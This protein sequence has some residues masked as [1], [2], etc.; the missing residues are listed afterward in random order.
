MKSTSLA[1][2]LLAWYAVHARE[3][4]WRGERDPYK[5]WVA[6]V[7]LQQT[8]VETVKPYYQRW[9][10][11]FPSLESLAMATQQE[12]LAAWE[13]L[14]YYSRAR[15]LHQAAQVVVKI[16]RG[17]IP[18]EV[19]SLRRLPGVGRY[20]AGAIASI[21][22]GK[23]VAA[24][25]GNQR[26]V[27][28]RLFDIDEPLNTPAGESRL[29]ELAEL[30]LPPRRAGDFNQALMD[31]GAT[32]CSPYAPACPECP[33][34]EMC[35]ARKLGVQEARPV[36]LVK[37]PTPH[38]PVAA[39]VIRRNGRVLITQRPADKLLGGMWEFPGG[40]QDDGE[41]LPAC[42]KRELLEELGVSVDVGAPFGVYR[43][44]YTHF[45]V[46]VHAFI[47]RL[48]RATQPRPLEGQAVRWCRPGELAD[49]P[50]GKVDRQIAKRCMEEWDRLS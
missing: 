13:G 11:L 35:K 21:A 40:K 32:L 2:Q 24:V 7:M 9:L 25:D 42:L 49:F 50:M 37:P 18:E 29:W 5:V 15:R 14:G 16:Y 33:L 44:A 34:G 22:F 47:C 46:T 31:L 30:H 20:T 48:G 12:A 45:K 43:H 41:D 10:Q 36:R 1:A 39:A 28:A 8:Q 19:E 27:L 4:P 23:D 3:L 38:Y 26:R 17:R 6:E